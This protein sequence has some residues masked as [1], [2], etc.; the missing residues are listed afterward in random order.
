MKNWQKI[1]IIIHIIGLLL[2]AILLLA[3]PVDDHLRWNIG[4]VIVWITTL[5]AFALVFVNVKHRRLYIGF[6]SYAAIWVLIILWSFTMQKLSYVPIFDMIYTP[7]HKYY[8]TD[9]YV[10]RSGHPGLIDYPR[11]A[12]WKKEG[13][14]EKYIRDYPSFETAEKFEIRSDLGA[15]IIHGTSFHLDDEESSDKYVDV[16]PL[17]DSVFYANRHKVEELKRELQKGVRQ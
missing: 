8:E 5:S 2:C 3:L 4:Y 9:G 10:M 6:K 14:M 7:Q 11:A 13:L 17:N 15:I 12:L 1:V 16:Y